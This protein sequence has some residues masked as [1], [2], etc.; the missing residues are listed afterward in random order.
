MIV[1]D[2]KGEIILDNSIT[3]SDDLVLYEQYKMKIERLNITPSAIFNVGKS[4]LLEYPT[5]SLDFSGLI[6][7]ISSITKSVNDNNSFI[8]SVISTIPE[9]SI[10]V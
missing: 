9:V 2:P 8:V 5:N 6:C 4:F 7:L 1:L 10:A 3:I